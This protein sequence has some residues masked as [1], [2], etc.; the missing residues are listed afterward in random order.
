MR[1]CEI[2]ALKMAAVAGLAGACGLA[3]WAG[4]AVAQEESSLIL[5]PVMA[6]PT[7]PGV[8]MPAQPPE[9]P[10]PIAVDEGAVAPMPQSDASVVHTPPCIKYDTNR[11]A[12]RMYAC[13]GSVELT[14]VVQNPADCCL[15]E[16]P[17][18]IPG[19][20]T[21][22]PVISSRCGL[23]GRGI[24]EY[25]WPCGF[26]AKVKFRHVLGDVRVDYDG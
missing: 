6:A 12:R 5:P 2:H 16:I 23:F 11:H 17:L 21:G 15:Y 3:A 13:S 24:V 1:N 20:C 18:C 14:M 25:C 10:Q 8:A 9:Q 4:I 19:C 7:Q 26:S 22:E